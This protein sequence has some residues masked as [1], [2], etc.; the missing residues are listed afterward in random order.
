MWADLILSSNHIKSSYVFFCDSKAMQSTLICLTLALW[1]DIIL[2][3]VVN[4]L[5]Y[6]GQIVFTF[7]HITA[8]LRKQNTRV[9]A[10]RTASEQVRHCT[11]VAFFLRKGGSM[12][13][14][15]NDTAVVTI[16]SLTIAWWDG[17]VVTLH[18]SPVSV[19]VFFGHSSHIGE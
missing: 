2:R 9:R 8:G 6:N 16:L 12:R 11:H 18:V 14:Y 19:W 5:L 1:D 13:F 7:N 15:I 3:L 17:A 10:H 4:N